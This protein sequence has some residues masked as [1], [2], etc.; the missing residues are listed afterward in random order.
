MEG[1]FKKSALNRLLCNK[2]PHQHTGLLRP[3]A[4]ENGFEGTVLENHNVLSERFLYKTQY[5]VQNGYMGLYFFFRKTF[6]IKI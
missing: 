6:H 5:K 1:R 4:P 3:R 2:G